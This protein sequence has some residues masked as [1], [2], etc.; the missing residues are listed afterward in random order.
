[1][2]VNDSVTVWPI[3]TTA[4]A[5]VAVDV[6]VIAPAANVPPSAGTTSVSE[7]SIGSVTVTPPASPFPLFVSVSVYLITCPG[8]GGAPP[9][10][11]THVF[12][13]PANSA[14]ATIVAQVGS[15]GSAV[16]GSSESTGTVTSSLFACPWLQSFVPS[17]TGLWTVP[18]IATV[19]GVG[20][21]QKR[22]IV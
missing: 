10:V 18:W 8:R 12:V 14:P 15:P 4:S 19:V 5:G 9:V 13:D 2:A 17:S 16:A 20:P 22:A 11:S 1:L 3:A 7:G 21:G 6:H